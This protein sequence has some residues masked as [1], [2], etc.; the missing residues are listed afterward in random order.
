MR[1]QYYNIPIDIAS[2]SE[3]LDLINE[4]LKGA[5]THT[6]FFI[7]AHCFNLAQAN[8][9]Y[10]KVLQESTLVFNDGI[11]IKLGSY[12]TNVKLKE[13]LNGTDLIPMV[14]ETCH[15]FDYPIYLL[16]GKPGIAD[17]AKLALQQKH[18]GINIC[19]VHHGY[20][21]DIE[22]Q[23]LDDINFCKPK[24]IIVGMGVPIQELWIAHHKSM[25]PSVNLLIA[26][27]AIID[28]ISGNVPRAP[29]WIRIMGMEWF[30]RFT[31]E[32]KRLWRRY[33][34]GNFEFFI[35]ILR[36]LISKK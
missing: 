31:L 28:F 8:T 1:K 15:K 10:L 34:F 23:I 24:L 3:A 6:L 22:K 16:G 30:Y 4:I 19:G 17:A 11:G 29:K 13:N 27:G 21:S 20:V 14:I 35:N 9:E 7:N 26:G 25:L 36:L 32:P 18:R 12:F 5:G 2:K 33:L